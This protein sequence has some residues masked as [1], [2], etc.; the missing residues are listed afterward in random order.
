[1]DSTFRGILREIFLSVS[2]E[3]AA[4]F[5]V[6][7]DKPFE[8]DSKLNSET[9][10]Y[11]ASQ[12]MHG[13]IYDRWF[14]KSFQLIVGTNGRVSCKPLSKCFFSWK[15]T[16]RFLIFLFEQYGFN[17]EHT[18]SDAPVLGKVDGTFGCLNVFLILSS[19]FFRSHG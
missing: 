9:M 14:D 17:A 5:L 19:S 11:Y 12:C 13:N 1:M 16:Q 3:S 6:L 2:V 18:W 15:D 7:H 10:A 4:L 8:F